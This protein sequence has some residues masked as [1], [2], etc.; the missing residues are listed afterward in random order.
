MIFSS[1][2]SHW[3]SCQVITPNLFKLY[4]KSF[5]E[6]ELRAFNYYDQI[7]NYEY[8]CM[9]ERLI[10]YLPDKII[11]CDHRPHPKRIIKDLVKKLGKEIPPVYC[12]LFGDFSLYAED[13]L[14]LETYLQNIKIKFIAASPRQA[15][16]VGQFIHER[17]KFISCL[18]FSVNE[19][20]YQFSPEHRKKVQDQYQ[21]NGEGK[22]FLY[23]GR[24]SAQKNIIFL[25]K[26][27]EQFLK[28]SGSDAH[29]YL[30]GTFDDMAYPFF[31]IYYPQG[32]T[33][34][35]FEQELE[36]Y[37]DLTR[38]RIHFLGNLASDELYDYYQACDVFVSLSLHNDEDYGM[39]PAEALCCGMPLIL[40]NWGGYA[41]FCL[42][43]TPTD[44]VQVKVV[45]SFYQID[46][47]NFI[48]LLVAY[49]Q[50]TIT[51]EVRV[52]LSLEGKE[53]F[54][55]ESN[56]ERLLK[57][58]SEPIGIFS[59]WNKKFQQFSNCFIKNAQNPFGI[60]SLEMTENFFGMGDK[61]QSKKIYR[62][63]YNEYI[64][65]I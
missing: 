24:F 17:E 55:M 61:I 2:E 5:P 60:Q 51:D 28:I 1:E 20:E 16:F 62:D 42:P 6:V 26:S 52:K 18:P 36:S 21:L 38:S 54:G 31:G 19:A 14:N 65:N 3:R 53:R 47:S 44:L 32:F 56:V 39:S 35:Q 29:L 33:Q 43:D 10:Q 9:I 22:N 57:I 8:F 49:D 58:H 46:Y 30:A 13:W 64:A 4:E 15:S 23:T 48:K 40:S 59:H 50:K 37:D 63:C 45:D 7:T 27:F 41:S 12:H 11:I 34:Y 25:I